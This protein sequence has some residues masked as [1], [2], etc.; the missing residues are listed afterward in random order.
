MTDRQPFGRQILGL[1][2][3]DVVAAE[4]A[5]G[6]GGR[7]L[8]VDALT[9]AALKAAFSGREIVG[10]GLA[11]LVKGQ[12][13]LL[14]DAFA[15]ASQQARGAWWLPD[16]MSLKAGLLNLPAHLLAGWRFSY[17][18]ARDEQFKASLKE[19]PDWMAVCAILQPLFATLLAPIEMRSQKVGTL[20]PEEA[21]QAWTNMDHA[22]IGLGL[23]VSDE[24][25]VLRYGSGW[26]RLRAEEQRQAKVAFARSLAGQV[27]IETAQRFRV[28][29]TSELID[30]YYAK[31]K[32]GAPTQRQV[33]TRALGQVL[34]GHFGGDWLAFL[35]YIEE[36]PADNEQ[37]TTSL[38]KPRL[39]VAGSDRVKE[40]AAAKGLAP[41]V[42]EA[43]LASFYGE[44]SLRSP[45]ERRV[46][47]M[48]R[49]FAELDSV[50][51]AQAP[52]MAAIGAPYERDLRR[53]LFSGELMAAVDSLGD[54]QCLPRWPER[55]VSTIDPLQAM[56]TAAGPALSFWH[57]V[58]INA[59]SLTEGPYTP[60]SLEGL[61]GL[62]EFHRVDLQ[63][64][65]D[66]GVP[67][68]AA[69]FEDLKAAEKR[70]GPPGRDGDRAGTWRGGA[71]ALL[72]LL[73]RR[74]HPPRRVRRPPGHHH[75]P[76]VAV[77]L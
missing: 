36:V 42:V 72:H 45:V 6:Q 18:M 52:G 28:M 68:Q 4:A 10:T 60:S 37:V 50:H 59:W 1:S 63:A 16:D 35:D 21:R 15:V 41:E 47:A 66:A 23:V 44:G 2:P 13:E 56:S 11:T 9:G 5:T 7:F 40:V 20:P 58:G 65:A 26:S 71:R 32:R 12:D 22:F 19:K 25:A 29:R 62:A 39:Y 70:L 75:I 8:P 17:G 67:V 64:L 31:A 49:C 54:G 30:R 76:P 61:A 43:M 24:L 14:A 53:S 34:A 73:R 27:G 55:I 51:A 46:E 38:P 3:G 57:L 69:L 77:G 48:R 74:R 33:V